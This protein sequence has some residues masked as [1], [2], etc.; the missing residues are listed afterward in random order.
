VILTTPNCKTSSSKIAKHSPLH[1]SSKHS[2]TNKQS[3]WTTTLH[4]QI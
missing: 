2:T 1:A 3:K 4:G